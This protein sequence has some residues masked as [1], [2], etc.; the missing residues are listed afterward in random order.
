MRD[1]KHMNSS[2]VKNTVIRQENG[3]RLLERSGE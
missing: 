1:R 3:T 2:D